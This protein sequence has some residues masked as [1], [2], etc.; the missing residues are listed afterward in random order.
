MIYFSNKTQQKIDKLIVTIFNGLHSL[1]TL[2]PIG[3]NTHEN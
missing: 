2:Y 1:T 3:I